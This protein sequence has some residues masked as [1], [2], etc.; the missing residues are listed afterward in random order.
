MKGKHAFVVSNRFI[1]YEFEIRRNITIIQGDSATGKTTLLNMLAA[2]SEDYVS[3]GIEVICDVP[4]FV[5]RTSGAMNWKTVLSMNE[6][7]IIFLEEDYDFVSTVEFAKYLEHSD[8]YFVIITRENLENLPYSVSEIYG[9][10]ESGKYGTT[11]QVYNFFE[12]VYMSGEHNFEIGKAAEEID[13]VITEDSKSG[14]QF[15]KTLCDKKQK[16][17]VSAF[18]KS[19]I[20]KCVRDNQ[21]ENQMVIID[22]AAFGSQ[23][24]RLSKMME[25]MEDRRCTVFLPESF[26]WVL[27]K[28]DLIPDIPELQNIMEK[29][30]EYV[31]S[32]E[33]MSWERFYATLIIK[34]SEGKIYQYSKNNLNEY[35]RGEKAIKKIKAKFPIIDKI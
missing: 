27:L 29:T 22:G 11:K 17:C 21:N 5:F 31:D 3:S 8:S 16:R 4:F 23:M 6:G 26:E 18:G 20:V 13:C 1:K 7:S 9:I 33:Y 35:Y 10:K 12:N 34:E 15:F 25:Q 14:F 2:Y 30:Y 19:N 28:A 32:K 24:R